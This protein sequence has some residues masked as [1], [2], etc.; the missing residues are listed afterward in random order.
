MELYGE[1]LLDTFN[2]D[3]VKPQDFSNVAIYFENERNYL[4]AGK[5]WFHARDY[6]KVPISVVNNVIMD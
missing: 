4:M 1:T 2:E 5:Y 6:Q 3:E